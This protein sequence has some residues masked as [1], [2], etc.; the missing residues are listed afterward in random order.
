MNKFK[1]LSIVQIK[2]MKFLKQKF[3][4]VLILI[5]ILC[6]LCNANSEKNNYKKIKSNDNNNK[7]GI[8]L[9]LDDK[10]SNSKLIIDDKKSNL[11][12]KNPVKEERKE[13]K[14]E[15]K[16]E[17]KEMKEKKEKKEVKAIE[18]NN[19]INKKNQ[20]IVPNSKNENIKP[21][22]NLIKMN[23]YRKNYNYEQVEKNMKFGNCYTRF[24][25]NEKYFYYDLD[26]FTKPLKIPGN[27]KILLS[28]CKN[29]NLEK[30]NGTGILQEDSQPDCKRYAGSH[31]QLKTWE[32]NTGK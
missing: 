14:K 19:N 16:E 10:N 28:F 17:K 32:I 22:E 31:R 9:N 29:L 24:K 4:I 7:I 25:K 20:K 27:E 18:K 21:F 8:K 23:N 12:L 13:E 5:N 30:C 15:G 11:K 2:K 1:Y 6:V 3:L 26:N